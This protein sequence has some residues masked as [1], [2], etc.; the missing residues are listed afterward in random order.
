MK[1]LILF[2]TITSVLFSSNSFSQGKKTIIDRI[3]ESDSIPVFVVHGK[4]KVDKYNPAMQK[5]PLSAAETQ[6]AY[7][8]AIIPT[9]VDTNQQYIVDLIN[10]RFNTTKFYLGATGTEENI[11]KIAVRDQTQ[12]F[13]YAKFFAEYS[14]D[15]T[16]AQRDMQSGNLKAILLLRMSC[17]LDFNTLK[18]SPLPID[19]LK[20]VLSSS[21]TK[22][23]MDGLITNAEEFMKVKSPLS[24]S[25]RVMTNL[26]E[27]LLEFSEKQIAK[28]E[29]II[30]K[31]K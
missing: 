30:S 31:R 19:R 26:D 7:I 16:P 6:K 24:L 9:I 23:Q 15:A 8:D 10:A 1:L 28:H 17:F 4:V 27:N 2:C 18:D 13:V 29:K 14:Y 5:V 3:E 22:V 12:F 20:T 11:D 25:T 21:L